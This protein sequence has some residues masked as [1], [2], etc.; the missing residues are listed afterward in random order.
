[1]LPNELYCYIFNFVTPT[2]LYNLYYSSKIFRELINTTSYLKE[3]KGKA[4]FI[5]KMKSILNNDDLATYIVRNNLTFFHDHYFEVTPRVYSYN[6]EKL[7]LDNLIS[8]VTIPIYTKGYITTPYYLVR[9]VVKEGN[10]SKFCERM[11][12]SEI[13]IKED[14]K[15]KNILVYFDY[16]IIVKNTN[17]IFRDVHTFKFIDKIKFNITKWPYFFCYRKNIF[18]FLECCFDQNN[19]ENKRAFVDDYNTYLRSYKKN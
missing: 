7:S 14:P 11:F 17:I 2:T 6:F 15:I 18:K 13:I 5:M 9:L 10:I 19:I 3:S 12:T 1:M 16:L 8:D 4:C